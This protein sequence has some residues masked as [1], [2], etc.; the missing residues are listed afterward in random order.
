TFNQGVPGSIPGRPTILRSRELSPKR[1]LRLVVGGAVAAGAWIVWRLLDGW[2]A[3]DDCTAPV[4]PDSVRWRRV[5]VIGGVAGAAALW[6]GWI[7]SASAE[8][9]HESVAA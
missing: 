1:E 5:P 2:F 3:K 8:E 9:R 4:V 6:L 7:V